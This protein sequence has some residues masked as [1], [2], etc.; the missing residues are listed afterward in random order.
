M[1]HPRTKENQ[2]IIFVGDSQGLFPPRL[3]DAVD[4]QEFFY[5]FFGRETCR[6]CAF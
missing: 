2:S 1:E 5:F 6:M 4:L 3:V